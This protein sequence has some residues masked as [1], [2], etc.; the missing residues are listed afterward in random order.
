MRT[1]T[2]IP[3][4]DIVRATDKVDDDYRP[5]QTEELCNRFKFFESY[6]EQEDEARRSRKKTF[7]FTPPRDGVVKVLYMLHCVRC[8]A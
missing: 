6:K 1:Q 8:A 3:E 4:T 7:R 2:S 5:I